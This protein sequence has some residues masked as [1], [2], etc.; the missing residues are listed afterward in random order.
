MKKL[1]LFLILL[2][3]FALSAIGQTA[4]GVINQV[5]CNNNGIYT[6]T[7][8]G[9][10]LPIT[11]TYYVN[12]TTVVH[13]NI[14]SATDQLQNFGMDNSGFIWCQA[15]GSGLSAWA[16]NSYTPS[17]TF[18]TTGT[19]P[20]CPATMGTLTASQISGTTGPFTYT[21]T[22]KQSLLTYSGN[23]ASVPIGEYAVEITDQTTGCV[24]QIND[25][26][27]YIQ[28]LSNVTGTI[29]TTTASCTNGTATVTAT[30]GVP[31][32]TYLR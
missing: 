17:F 6:V 13:A 14:N 15:T 12:G 29:T 22:N 19:S 5:P 21:W 7:T 9:I 24:L 28:Q 30:G 20:V 2:L 27:V 32:Y 25:S 8:T 1:S 31:P 18:Y 3:S 23:N 4:T 16:Q 26:A 10:P 11:Y